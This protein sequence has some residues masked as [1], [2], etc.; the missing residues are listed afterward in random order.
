M[1]HAVRCTFLLCT[2]TS[3]ARAMD[4]A[5]KE[6]AEQCRRI[7]MQAFKAHR[8]QQ[9]YAKPCGLKMHMFGSSCAP[10]GRK[11]LVVFAT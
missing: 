7:G 3:L 6:Q 2:P 8:E 5:N 11:A 4:N 10:P 9:G 1:S